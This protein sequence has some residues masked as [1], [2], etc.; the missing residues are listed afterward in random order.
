LLAYGVAR[1]GQVL[2]PDWIANLELVMVRFPPSI[3]L[4]GVRTA[5]VDL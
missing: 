3:L 4:Q 2:E 5:V 1:F